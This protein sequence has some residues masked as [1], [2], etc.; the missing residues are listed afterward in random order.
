MAEAH[1]AIQGKVT[2]VSG[3]AVLGAVITIEGADRNRRTTVTDE[4]G[5]FQISSFAAG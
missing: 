5:T 2:D 3:A 4:N 1:G